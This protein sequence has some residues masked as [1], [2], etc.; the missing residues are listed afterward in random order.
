VSA[1]DSSA[2]VDALLTLPGVAAAQLDDDRDDG[3][4]TLRLE[5]TSAADEVGVAAAVNRLLREQFGLA[6][7]TGRV[8][9]FDN[10]A[11]ATVSAPFVPVNGGARNGRR[12]R[13]PAAG[14]LRASLT[15]AVQTPAPADRNGHV[16]TEGAH[17]APAGQPPSD[18]QPAEPAPL[19]PP[20]PL[21][22]PPSPTP[23]VAQTDQRASARPSR[24]VIG[25]VRFR[26]TGLD[27]HAAVSLHAGDRELVGEARCA[28]TDSGV[29]RVVAAAT[30]RAL[31]QIADD[32]VR[33]DVEHVDVL[34]TGTER[35]A[36]CLVSMLTAQGAERLP[37]A[38]VVR[39]DVRQAVVRA[40]LAA[41]NRQVE[42]L[43]E[44]E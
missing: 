4:G 41:L 37:G 1:T 6:V 21:A 43:Q 3:E 34:T 31:E 17:H 36:L 44:D 23:A 42:K 16:G 22:P 27:A 18:L 26:V 35:T 2:L 19:T 29:L 8:A 12:H 38:S 40:T 33:F 5:L 20:T 32:R 25:R 9:L 24:L 13:P 10:A 39:G 30:V 15:S 11:G 28:A 14:P 7:D